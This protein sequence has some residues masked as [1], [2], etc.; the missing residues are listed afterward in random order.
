MTNDN[1][2]TTTNDNATLAVARLDELEQEFA[3]TLTN[4]V[5]NIIRRGELL[6]EIKETLGHGEWLPWLRKKFALSQSTAQN[7]MN[8]ATF[9]GKYP[10]VRD[11]KIGARALYRLA[12][13]DSDLTSDQMT[14]LLGV[15]KDCWIGH[16]EIDKVLRALRAKRD[17][18]E[19]DDG[20]SVVPDERSVSRVS[21]RVDA[22]DQGLSVMLAF[23]ERPP[24]E[25]VG[26]DYAPAT[27][28]QDLRKVGD[29]L[30]KLAEAVESRTPVL[31]AA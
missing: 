7:Y 21:A 2:N 15:G 31:E 20:P 14:T 13:R 9:A 27:S 25:F 6:I 22:F 8:A 5:P 11:L 24:S 3:A 17:V 18:K 10:T 29:F 12:A 28:A 19:I 26:D 4:D 23:A 30:K 16:K 1:A